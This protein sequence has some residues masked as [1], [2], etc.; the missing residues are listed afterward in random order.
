MYREL[1]NI[2]KAAL[3]IMKIKINTNKIKA[4]TK[5]FRLIFLSPT[6]VLCILL[7][8][9]FIIS[10]VVP[11]VINTASNHLVPIYNVDRNDKCISL[12]VDAA[13]GN[14]YT[15]KIIEILDKYNVTI[16]FFTVNFWAE[17]Y[18][19]DI[20]KLKLHGHEIGNHSATHP[21]M[22]KLSKEK[23]REELLT[24]WETQKKYAGS[25]AVRLFRA[26][27][28]SYNNLLIE[29]CREYGFEC[30]QWDVDS[31]DWKENANV[32]DVV[33]R[34]L[35][36]TKSGSIILMHN[37]S[38]VITQVLP[39]VIEGLL[40]EGYTFVPVS[41]LIYKGNSNIDSNGTQHSSK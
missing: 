33:N 36:K 16:T 5:K 31:I 13:W 25:S 29:T 30:I 34:V 15:D 38:S 17:E 22:A 9:S 4:V 26:P 6:F 28:G 23:I 27:Y 39:Q 10:Q 2:L 19:E 7:A 18:P 41:Q 1:N 35:T 32:D 24:T 8:I 11:K 12:T 14:E 37:N 20:E 40:N 21:D 3:S